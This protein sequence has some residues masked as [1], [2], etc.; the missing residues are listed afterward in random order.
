MFPTIFISLWLLYA[1]AGFQRQLFICFLLRCWIFI[2]FI[3]SSVYEEVQWLDSL[4]SILFLFQEMRVAAMGCIDGLYAL[5]RRFDFSSKKNGMHWWFTK[6]LYILLL[7]PSLYTFLMYIF[8]VILTG[9]GFGICLSGLICFGLENEWVYLLSINRRFLC[10]SLWNWFSL[11]SVLFVDNPL[12]YLLSFWFYWYS[13]LCFL[14]KKKKIV[15]IFWMVLMTGSTAL[16]SHFLDDLLGLMV[17]QKRLILSDKKF[18]SSFMTSLLSSSCNSLLVPESIGQR[19]ST[20]FIKLVVLVGIIM[21]CSFFISWKYTSP[22]I[23]GA[24][25]KII[26]FFL[27]VLLNK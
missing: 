1:L 12:L 15:V 13:I 23:L 2:S 9:M 20:N 11:F 14:W 4:C 7:F 10:L 6:I 19:Y 16:W 18:L 26:D 25:C 21:L 5:W 22:H 3:F 17:Q 24:I 27:M 8:F